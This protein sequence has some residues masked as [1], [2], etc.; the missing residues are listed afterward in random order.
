VVVGRRREPLEAVVTAVTSSGGWAQ[1]RQLDVSDTSAIESV[2]GGLVDEHGR[3]DVLVNSAAVAS[4]HAVAEVTGN[5][6]DAVLGANARGTFMCV[7]EF[8]KAPA[9][10]GRSV[11]NV[12][13][14]ASVAGVRGQSAYVASKGAV[15]SLTRALA[16]ELAREEIRVNAIAPGYFDTDMPAELLADERATESL[17]RRIPMRRVGSPEEIAGAVLFLAAPASSYV[18]GAIIHV[19]GG[20]TAQ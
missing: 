6:W 18:T 4:E 7:R 3:L 1:W 13:S 16:V 12:A 19:D 11:V 2:F 20:Y 8:A 14:L 15:A 10:P 9:N 5:D 17:L